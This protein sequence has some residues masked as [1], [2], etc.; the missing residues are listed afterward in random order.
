MKCLSMKPI[1]F[2]FGI[3]KIKNTAMLKLGQLMEYSNRKNFRGKILLK[4]GS[5]N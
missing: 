4:I 2:L 3:F 5:G 1:Y